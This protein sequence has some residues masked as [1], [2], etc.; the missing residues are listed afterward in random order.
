MYI[1]CIVVFSCISEQSELT[2]ENSELASQYSCIS[3][4][5]ELTQVSSYVLMYQNLQV[6]SY[7]L[8]YLRA[9]IELTYKS[10]YTHVYQSS[11]NLHVS[12]YVLMYFRAFQTYKSV[13]MYSCIT[14]QSELTS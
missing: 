11:H 7:V 3:E 5:S 1:R 13:Y 4:Q 9:F 8:V 12:S 10:V 14:V 2:S 6:S